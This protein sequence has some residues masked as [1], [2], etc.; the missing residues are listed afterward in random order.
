MQAASLLLVF[1]LVKAIVLA[2]HRVPLSFWTPIACVWQDALVVLVWAAIEWRLGPRSRAA[3]LGYAVLTIYAAINIPVTRALA[4]PLTWPMLRAAGGPLADS[5]RHY[6]TWPNVLAPAGVV[7]VAALAP[8]WLARMPTRPVLAG[9][10]LCVL[11]GP[12][13]AAHVDTLGLERNAWSALVNSVWHRIALRPAG[14]AAAG[15]SATSLSETR[16]RHGAIESQNRDDLSSLRGAAAG[17]HIIL[18]SLESTAAR[19]LGLYGA[20]PDV[21]PAL[22]ALAE[23]GVVFAHAYAVYPES[24]KGLFSILCSMYPAFDSDAEAYARVPCASIASSLAAAGYRTGLFHAGRFAYLGMNAVIR[25]RG[26]ATLADAGDIGGQHNSS[27]GVDEPSTVARILTWI[28][29]LPAGQRF[30]AT[31]LPIAGHHPYE[32]PTAGPFPE[33]DELGRYRNAL[34]YGDE[35]LGALIRGIRARGLDRETLWIVMGDHGEAFGQHDGNYGHTFQLYDENVRVPF[36]IAAPGLIE[37]RIRSRRVVSLIDTAPTV[38]DLVGVPIPEAY[39][40]A[41]MLDNTPRRAL[42]FADYSLRLL[43]LRD[44]PLKFIYEIE[45]GRSRLF[46]ID[47]DPGE[48]RNLSDREVNRSHAF[49]RDLLAWS[50]AQKSLITNHHGGH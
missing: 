31:Y 43:G 27:F 30:F 23:S 28:D 5:I 32:T 45:S 13:A 38:L 10:V 40:G 49:A 41:S 20:S 22:S 47:E 9:L 24:I 44:G 1:V 36:L 6:L 21:A 2:G 7:A 8:A 46:N 3:W 17:R 14:I 19:Y 35:A 26:Y 42:F 16:W 34:R 15:H 18:V 48:T 25:N 39:Q 11:A 50:G 4:T 12:T 33:H 37:G 29:S